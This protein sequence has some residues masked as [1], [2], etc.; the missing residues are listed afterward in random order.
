MKKRRIS[1]VLATL[2]IISASAF[3]LA[4]CGNESNSSTSTDNSTKTTDVVDD[5]KVNF[6]VDGKIYQTLTIENG[7][8]VMPQ[9]PT[10]EGYNFKGWYLDETYTKAFSNN[11]VKAGNVYA[12]FQQI[13]IE[14]FVDGVSLGE[15]TSDK[16][17]DDVVAKEN[18]TLD[19]WYIDEA[20]TTKYTNQDVDKLYARN[21][22][23][24]TL[25]DGYQDIKEYLVK[26]NNKLTRPEIDD[27]KTFYMDETSIKFLNSDN[28]EF[29]FDIEISVNT[30]IN[31]SWASP[32]LKYQLSADK[33]NVYCDGFDASHYQEFKQFPVIRIPAEATVKVD[34]V[35]TK[36]PVYSAY[37]W[38]NDICKKVI[39]SEGIKEIVKLS[40][41]KSLE[42]VVLP[43]SLEIISESFNNCPKLKEI[44]LPSNLKAIYDS[45]WNDPNM[46][47]K[48]E[49]VG[50]RVTR[51]I[52]YEF[53]IE[54]PD[55]VI[56]MTSVPSN[57]KFGDNSIF[58]K[59]D[60]AIYTNVNNKKVLVSSLE[61]TNGK[62]E[63]KEGVKG[64]QAG[65]FAQLDVDY[66][67]LPSTFEFV[68]TNLVKT[69][70]SYAK[71]PYLF[72]EAALAE[73]K[74]QHSY[75]YSIY[76]RLND[77]KA[78]IV[79]QTVFNPN[80][81][82]LVLT[83]RKTMND[84]IAYNDTSFNDILDKVYF[85][86]DA[87]YEG[88]NIPSGVYYDYEPF[89]GY[90]AKQAATE[91]TPYIN[92]N[93]YYTGEYPYNEAN[94][95]KGDEVNGTYYTR[96]NKYEYEVTSDIYS[97]S[98]NKYYILNNGNYQSISIAQGALLSEVGETL[99]EY[100]YNYTTDE[101]FRCNVQYL[102]KIDKYLTAVLVKAGDSIPANQYYELNAGEYVLTTDTTFV[103]G[104]KY[105]NVQSI[106]NRNVSKKEVIIVGDSIPANKYY[107]KDSNNNYSLTTDT[108][109]VDGKTYYILAG[110][111]YQNASVTVGDSIP[112]NKYYVMDY[113][114][115]E[116]TDTVFS[117]RKVYYERLTDTKYVY[118]AA[119]VTVGDSISTNKYYE[120]NNEIY[121]L[122]T[123]T[124]FADGKTYY[125]K[126][127]FNANEYY[128]AEVNRGASLNS[129]YYE[130][131]NNEYVATTD[132]VARTGKTYYTRGKI[133]Y[134]EIADFNG[135]DEVTVT[136]F[137]NN[138]SISSNETYKLKINAGSKITQDEILAACNYDKDSMKILSITELNEEY[139]FDN[140]VKRNLYFNISVEYNT[141]GFT[142][143][144]NQDGT[145]TVTG[146]DENTAAEL[147]DG[148]YLVV[149][150]SE[151]DNKEIV[152][153][154]E[155]AFKDND[156]IKIMIVA[157]TIKTIG[158]SAFENTT[159]LKEFSVAA[160]GL[161]EIKTNAFLNST[162]EKITIPL[163][164]LTNVEPYA[165]KCRNLIGF[166]P[167]KGEENRFIY[168]FDMMSSTS[169]Q[170]GNEEI[171]KYFFTSDFW[172]TSTSDGS[173]FGIL[174]YVGDTVIKMPT[175]EGS[176]TTVDVPVH[177]AQLISIAAGRQIQSSCTPNM[178]WTNRKNGG[179][180]PNDVIRY[181]IMEGSYY[182][183]QA[184]FLGPVKYIHKNA[185]TDMTTYIRGVYQNIP[186]SYGQYDHYLDV[187]KVQNMDSSIFEAGWYN[188]L[189]EGT[190][191]DT[192]VEKMKECYYWD[193]WC[194]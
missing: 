42:E 43:E 118:T 6:M 180:Y 132:T 165:F 138:K 178:G 34:N 111:T 127:T 104:K 184:P 114:Y 60:N 82:D 182:Y 63:V 9:N 46:D 85:I 19:K 11:D 163:A 161:E 174:K 136:L 172:Q 39:F 92:G 169:Y 135:V 105:Y 176:E 40:S 23:K 147:S 47:L 88:D 110:I 81:N 193:L 179:I 58:Y 167:V 52:A 143:E 65:C 154:K 102:E 5:N 164:S 133:V 189:T 173:H 175:A 124:T 145:V 190:D 76:D 4:S 21:M 59:E 25:N 149:I 166:Y 73:A 123:D 191:Y 48:G 12:L 26:P 54:I 139:N 93:K 156:S 30:T 97:V 16:L 144:E 121:V 157:S 74:F 187:D 171:G 71:T 100:K 83:G 32:Y 192:L 125:V 78:V 159:A 13:T 38:T 177:D 44:K 27:V 29:D 153:I 134:N 22:A 79:S 69:D 106:N 152:A 66:L 1:K 117:N 72:D 116:T 120:L 137:Y 119:S 151:I 7:Q 68:N 36:L 31:V 61:V 141:T 146:F 84:Y 8:V 28:N 24:V 183:M 122:T 109:F 168:N 155:N 107:E 128:Q 3:A 77:I 90:I 49:N 95:A 17:E 94:V 86:G 130:L 142:Y 41:A 194:A 131:I 129:N 62:L 10:K 160:G 91:G 99:Y 50:N 103:S 148:Y 51:N 181:E 70:Y 67:Y 53:D 20:C 186:S 170:A 87:D 2:G 15:V 185:F 101:T 140:I 18:L 35:D 75:Q 113:E 115:T 57:L 45:F 80:I 96:S 108:T 162:V 89:P 64:I 112:A 55:S 150:P 33:T 126:S 188:G 98:R 158:K 14:R 56:N 37:A